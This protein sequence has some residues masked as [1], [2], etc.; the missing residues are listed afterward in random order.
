M[1]VEVLAVGTE[2]LLGQTVNTN[3]AYLGE[4]LAELGLDAHYQ[5]VVGDN[6]GRMVATIRTAIDRADAVII[7]GGL[8]P[9]QD[10]ITREAI[11]AATGRSMLFSEEHAA[12]LRTFW[13][14][15]GREFP[16][17]NLCQAEYPEGAAQL[18]NHRGTA[19]G[20]FLDHDR[21]LI[22]ALP[23]VPA[24]LYQMIEEHVIPRLR[25]GTGTGEV[26]VSRVLR[27]WGHG[28]SAVADLLDDL[29]HASVNPSM[30]FLASAGEVKVRLSAKAGSD[31]EARSMI[32]PVEREV[33]RR[34]GASVFA[35]D[36]ESLEQILLDELRVRGWKIGTAESLTSGMVAARLSL[37]PG[38][39][40]VFRGSVITYATD[41]KLSMLGVPQ[42]V[43]DAH[44]VVS[45]ETAVA[46]ADGAARVMGVDVATALTGVA[47]PEALE[48]SPGSVVVAV[49][50]PVRTRARFLKMPGDRERVRAYTTTTAL[51]LTRLAVIG[52]WW[53]QSL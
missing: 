9:T 19:P 27:T 17:S 43:I 3:A 48:H 33:R 31:E 12:E 53:K 21:T 40:E 42:E 52:E 13:D 10:D 4:R 18:V 45:S 11:C 23:G 49:R 36:D 37:L 8:G 34:L 6:H 44:G 46:M 24:E 47:G 38:S 50:T 20:L 2:L 30:A 28:E 51:Q 22:F 26:L 35:T 14:R 25:E 1:I 5:V 29:Y 32:D 7:T 39:S 16:E 41:L 15:L